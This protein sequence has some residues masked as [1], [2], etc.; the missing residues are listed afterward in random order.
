MS[1]DKH[2]CLLI[3]GAPQELPPRIGNVIKRSSQAKKEL[4]RHPPPD[5]ISLLKSSRHY[6]RARHK[7]L[8]S[9]CMLATELLSRSALT[10]SSST[11]SP[12]SSAK[13]VQTLPK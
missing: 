5:F 2:L 12:R 11:G 6:A 4:L 7:W 13:F 10:R 3:F 1:G 9:H 8:K